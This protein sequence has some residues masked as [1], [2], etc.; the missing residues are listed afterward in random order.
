MNK[1]N[2]FQAAALIG[3]AGFLAWKEF[4]KFKKELEN[5]NLSSSKNS[6]IEEND[7]CKD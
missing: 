3:F 5:E 7:R 4:L 6:F 1:K 2:G